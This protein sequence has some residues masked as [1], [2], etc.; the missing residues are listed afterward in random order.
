MLPGKVPLHDG[1]RYVA[2]CRKCMTGFTYAYAL[3][4]SSLGFT[5]IEEMNR[6]G[7][8]VD[9]S[10]TSDSTAIQA[11]GHSRAPVI[12]SHSSSRTIHNHP[13]NVPDDVL[14]LIGTNEGQR[15]AVVMV[16]GWLSVAFHA[17]I[18]PFRLILLQ[19]LLLHRGKQTSKQLLTTWNTFQR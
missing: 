18:F 10:H 19:I 17:L 7:V 12:W 9:L 4:P 16:F 2:S 14:R 3:I 6:L 15:D 5:L 8:L 1:L 11:L 13:R